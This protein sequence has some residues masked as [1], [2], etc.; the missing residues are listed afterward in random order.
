[1]LKIIQLYCFSKNKKLYIHKYL[2]ASL[3]L[4]Y[5]FCVVFDFNETFFIKD[6]I[7]KA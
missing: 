5:E 3:M 2:M 6:T 4:H 7:K 1:M